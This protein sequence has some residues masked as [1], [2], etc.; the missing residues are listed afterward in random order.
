[1]SR[2]FVNEDRDDDVPRHHFVL[3]SRRSR[4]F[5][6]AAALLLLEAARDGILYDAEQATGLKWGD[7]QFRPHIERYLAEE[8]ARPEPE[9]DTRFIQVAKR[10][11]RTIERETVGE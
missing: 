11:L 6:A 9:Q 7:P 5:D 3:P 8:R 4:S 1:M 2:A 10:Y